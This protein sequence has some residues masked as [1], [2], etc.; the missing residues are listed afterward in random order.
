MTETVSGRRAAASRWRGM[1][2]PLAVPLAAGA[3]AGLGHPPFDLWFLTPLG[4]AVGI[5]FLGRCA[6]PGAGFRAGL[7]LG[8]GYFAVALHWIVEPFLTV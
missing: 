4:L 1:A 2:G 5:W 7:A 8:A 6:T 3:L